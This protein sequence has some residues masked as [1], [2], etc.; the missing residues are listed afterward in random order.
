MSLS[1]EIGSPDIQET[2]IVREKL[3]QDLTTTDIAILSVI[4][5]LNQKS[6]KHPTTSMI[7]KE[8][9]ASH[10]LRRTQL[11]ERLSHLKELGFISV[12]PFG[13]PRSYGIDKSTIVSGS[14]EWLRRQKEALG[15]VFNRVED[16]L[17]TFENAT[18][19]E[20]AEIIH[21]AVENNDGHETQERLPTETYDAP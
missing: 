13:R 3:F 7:Q 18:P 11:Y 1:N 17:K 4:F 20:V 10:P 14:S 6:E 12:N 15:Q 8:M 5:R 19:T 21:D 9:L 2:S 16:L